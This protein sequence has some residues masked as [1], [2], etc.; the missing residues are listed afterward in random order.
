MKPDPW[1]PDLLAVVFTIVLA[2]AISGGLY[3]AAIAEWFL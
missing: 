2:V 1:L 3:I